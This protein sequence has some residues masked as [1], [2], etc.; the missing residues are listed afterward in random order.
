LGLRGGKGRGGERRKDEKGNNAKPH[1]NLRFEKRAFNAVDSTTTRRFP[2]SVPRDI[3]LA[4]APP[5]A[6]VWPT[7]PEQGPQ[8]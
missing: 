4:T 5:S 7:K 2:H 6:R 3:E 1:D 8:A